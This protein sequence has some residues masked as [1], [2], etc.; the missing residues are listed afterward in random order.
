MVHVGFP[1]FGR[2]LPSLLEVAVELVAHG[3]AKGVPHWLL[4]AAELAAIDLR[5]SLDE[6]G[7]RDDLFGNLSRLNSVEISWLLL[8]LH[9]CLR[10]R[11]METSKNLLSCTRVMLVS[12]LLFRSISVASLGTRSTI[13]L[14]LRL[15]LTMG[16]RQRLTMRLRLWLTMRLRLRLTIILLLWLRLKMAPAYT[17]HLRTQT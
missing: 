12:H 9:L 4:A 11:F 16:L 2:R 15:R 6:L 10:L 14:R 5:L 1:K 7:L 17:T 8:L 13:R 3:I